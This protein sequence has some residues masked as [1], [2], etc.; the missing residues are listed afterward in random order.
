MAFWADCVKFV[1][2][3]V[4]YREL[5][6]GRTPIKF[7]RV[8]LTIPAGE[9]SATYRIEGI[10]PNHCIVSLSGGSNQSLE[11]QDMHVDNAIAGFSPVE[12]SVYVLHREIL[13]HPMYYRV[14]VM[15]TGV[16]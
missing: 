12:K 9:R 3:S 11:V 6:S 5:I 4:F 13:D 10:I 1:R 7:E 15:Y 16:I 8:E 14:D 2:S